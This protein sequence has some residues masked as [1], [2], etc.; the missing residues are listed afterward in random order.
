MNE[1]LD[2]M[3][4]DYDTTLLP[5]LFIDLSEYVVRSVRLYLQIREREIHAIDRDK[6]DQIMKVA[7]VLS[8]SA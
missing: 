8:S 3:G 5:L 6:F 4:V 2:S 1:V 7:G